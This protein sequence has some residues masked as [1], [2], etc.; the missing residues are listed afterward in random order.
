[1]NAMR[2]KKAR[3]KKEKKIKEQKKSNGKNWKILW[4]PWRTRT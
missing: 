4:L 2:M 1:M 3:A